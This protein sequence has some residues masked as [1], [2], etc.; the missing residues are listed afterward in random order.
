MKLFRFNMIF[1]NSKDGACTVSTNQSN[2]II[3]YMK[4]YSL[5]V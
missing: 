3:K 5:F 2:Q 4:N 1:I